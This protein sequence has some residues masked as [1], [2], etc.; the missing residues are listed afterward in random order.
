MFLIISIYA[1]VDSEFIDD[2]SINNDIRANIRS[3]EVFSH[4]MVIL[5]F[6]LTSKVTS[7]INSRGIVIISIYF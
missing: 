6:I 2:G 1:I 5:S 4:H 7:I 3:I